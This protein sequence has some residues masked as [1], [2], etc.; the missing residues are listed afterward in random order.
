MAG[1]NRNV[2]IMRFTRRSEIT[3]DV[4]VSSLER[5]VGWCED[6]VGAVVGVLFKMFE[7]E[8]FL[9]KLCARL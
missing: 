1:E 9:N 3:Y 6:E 4:F 7:L 5:D 2:V 8:A